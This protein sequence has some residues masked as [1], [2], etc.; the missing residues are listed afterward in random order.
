M[1]QLDQEDSSSPPPA[2]THLKPIYYIQHQTLKK[3]LIPLPET[4][5][6]SE[7]LF[8]FALPLDDDDG[9]GDASDDEE[10]S[11]TTVTTSTGGRRI[12]PDMSDWGAIVERLSVYAKGNGKY[13]DD[14][15]E[16]D[17]F[18]HEVLSCDSI[19]HLTTILEDEEEEE[20]EGSVII[21]QVESSS[22]SGSSPQSTLPSRSEVEELLQRL[23]SCLREMEVNDD[24]D[25]SCFENLE[26]SLELTIKMNDQSLRSEQNYQGRCK[27]LL[28]SGKTLVLNTSIGTVGPEK[29]SEGETDENYAVSFVPSQEFMKTTPVYDLPES[30]PPTTQDLEEETQQSGPITEMVTIVDY[31][32][33]Q[34]QSPNKRFLLFRISCEEVVLKMIIAVL[35]IF[36][37]S[38][39]FFS[40]QVFVNMQAAMWR[41]M[42]SICQ[43]ESFGGVP[44]RPD[45]LAMIVCLFKEGTY[46]LR[47]P[48][49]FQNDP[50]GAWLAL[51]QQWNSTGN[52]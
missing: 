15:E 50:M 19:C 26:S 31:I 17:R 10:D 25:D 18:R 38:R 21:N 16:N 27:V 20:W 45:F 43:V 8:A 33:V 51:A 4:V 12:L 7:C 41:W 22:S 11:T 6:P 44:I 9:N 34:N 42:D 48:I 5:Q 28:S 1:P 35:V 13:I 36:H 39:S 52:Y 3:R 23:S 2:L 24:Y 32:P 29:D 37:L 30:S 40:D 14:D 49:G 46:H 47:L